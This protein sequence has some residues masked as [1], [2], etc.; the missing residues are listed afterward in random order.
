[1]VG[2]FSPLPSL[3][4]AGGLVEPEVCYLALV[5]VRAP[6]GAMRVDAQNGSLLATIPSGLRVV[7]QASLWPSCDVPALPPHDGRSDS[8]A[9][10]K[11]RS[12]SPTSPIP[13]LPTFRI[14][15]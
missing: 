9:P 3:G 14:P 13:R 5:A 10:Q 15:L 7:E 1:M 8:P 12:S 2:W 11:R 4:Y 6:P